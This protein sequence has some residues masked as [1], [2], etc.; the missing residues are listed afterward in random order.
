MMSA[1]DLNDTDFMEDNDERNDEGE[2]AAKKQKTF[3]KRV[4]ID[5]KYII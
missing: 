4:C 3:P 5:K 1:W 2:S